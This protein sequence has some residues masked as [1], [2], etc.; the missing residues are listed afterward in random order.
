[1]T[2]HPTTNH[3]RKAA[4]PHELAAKPPLAAVKA[5]GPALARRNRP[6][7]VM[8][9]SDMIERVAHQ[10]GKSVKETSEVVNATLETIREALKGGDEV[11]LTGFGAFGVRTRAAHTGVNLQ[12]RAK[13]R[14]PAKQHVRFSVGKGLSDAVAR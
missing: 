12:T 3:Q 4:A 10:S 1:M 13:I 2:V 14:V 9:K 6:L 11:R 5:D 8:S 7:V